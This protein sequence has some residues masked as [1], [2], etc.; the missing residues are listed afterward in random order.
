MADSACNA[1]PAITPGQTRTWIVVRLPDQPGYPVIDR[2]TIIKALEGAGCVAAAEEADE[3]LE[4]ASN[5]SQLHSMVER[6]LRGEPLAWITGTTLFC[7]LAV[8]VAPGVYVPRWQSEQL[9]KR[10]ADLLPLHGLGIDLC[11]GSGA[12]AMVMQAARPEASVLGT[13]LSPDAARCARRNGVVVLEGSLDEP[14][15]R[16][17]ASEVDVMV[18]VLPY[19]PTEALRF[20]PRDVQDFEPLVALDGGEGG[21]ALVAQAVAASP[22]W[23]KQGGWLMLEIGEDQVGQIAGLLATAGY[24]SIELIEDGDGD[25][26]GISGQRA[27]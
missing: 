14:L 27:G 9:A 16:R 5:D 24:G 7:G 23:V 21:L 25:V 11:T 13:E 4:A 2:A 1:E 26:R 8:G 18:G 15:P 3:L 17:I 20:L 6:R 19:V 10:A 22:T 12:I